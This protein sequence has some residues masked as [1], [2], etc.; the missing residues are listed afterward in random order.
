MM[1][2]LWIQQSNIVTWKMALLHLGKYIWR[3]EDVY[4]YLNIV[5]NFKPNKGQK[6]CDFHPG[7]GLVVLCGSL[8]FGCQIYICC[9]NLEKA[10]KNCPP[11]FIECPFFKVAA[12]CSIE[13]HCAIL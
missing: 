12:L 6:Q 4:E 2:K 10:Y 11:S 8:K 7:S 5:E 9:I 3:V 1:N 13:A